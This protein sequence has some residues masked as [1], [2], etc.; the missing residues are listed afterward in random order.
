[1]KIGEVLVEGCMCEVY[2]RYT[3]KLEVYTNLSSDMPVL[4]AIS[5]MKNKEYVQ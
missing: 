3:A 5:D 2:F 4:Y 1:M